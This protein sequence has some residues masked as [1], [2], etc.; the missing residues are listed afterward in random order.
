MGRTFR[1]RKLGFNFR[2]SGQKREK[3]VVSSLQS[4]KYQKGKKAWR[5]QFTD[6]KKSIGIV[7]HLGAAHLSESY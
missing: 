2:E 1:A 3:P 7:S 4:K 5:P 6:I